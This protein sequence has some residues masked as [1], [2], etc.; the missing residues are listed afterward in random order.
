MCSRARLLCGWV[1][2]AL[3]CGS[4][5]ACSTASGRH[6]LPPDAVLEPPSVPTQQ[7]AFARAVKSQLGA[8]M[9]GGTGAALLENGN[10]FAGLEEAVRGAKSSIHIDVYI[11]RPCQI[12][13]EVAQVVAEKAR[14]GVACRVVVDSAGSH[15]FDGI[16]KIIEPAGCEVRVFR[17]PTEHPKE[18]LRRDHRKIVVVDGRVAI[19]GGFGIYKSW[20]GSGRSKEEWRDTNIRLEGPVVAQLQHAFEEDWRANG[21][22]PLGGDAYP[23]L[24]P[25][26]KGNGALVTSM[27]PQDS[28]DLAAAEKMLRF[29][30]GAAKKRLWIANS[31]FVPS[32]EI[33][34]MLEA[35]AREGV[36]VRVLD[37]GPELDH[38]TIRAAQRAAY[39]ELVAAGVKMFEYQPT[40]M[41]AKTVV[42]DD[43]I[44]AVGSTNMDPLS[45]KKLEEDTVVIEDPALTAQLAAHF[46]QDLTYAEPMTEP[47]TNPV[48]DAARAAYWGVGKH[49]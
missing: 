2:I 3:A 40:M 17:P 16:R 41:H 14:Q 4:G 15:D 8:T 5:V 7:G 1:V 45:L 6:R 48:Y 12:G 36:D 47:R 10:V 32:D 19:T 24:R 30:I 25:A 28:N 34:K 11:W 9:V 46:E 37:P 26:G 33:L 39:P 22:A 13:L 49:L 44:V 35:K 43:R 18:T 21:G 31:Y 27:G 42:V 29:L 20:T 38:G 23:A